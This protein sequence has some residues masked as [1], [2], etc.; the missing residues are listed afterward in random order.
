[1]HMYMSG[2]LTKRA[3]RMHAHCSDRMLQNQPSAAS[4]EPVSS[5]EVFPKD[6][7]NIAGDCLLLFVIIILAKKTL[8]THTNSLAQLENL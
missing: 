6:I 7:E 2:N 4:N 5:A 8:T 3:G 1:M